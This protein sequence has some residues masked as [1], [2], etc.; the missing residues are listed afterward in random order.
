M[1]DT[2]QNP[3]IMNALKAYRWLW[4]SPVFTILTLIFVYFL[5]YSSFSAI[6]ISALW[7]LLLLRYVNDRTSD[8]VRWHGRQALM[9][10]GIR[11]LIPLLFVI[12]GGNYALERSFWPFILLLAAY[13]IGNI[14]GV[15]QAV[16]GDCWLMR[17][18]GTGAELPL[19]T[20][21]VEAESV[22]RT[23]ATSPITPAMA[24][25]SAE[26]LEQ[27]ATLNLIL[28][29][30]SSGDVTR[31]MKAIRELETIRFSSEAIVTQLERLALEENPTVRK[32]ALSALN[33]TTSQFVSSR[34]SS[35]VKSVRQI[36]L[37]EIEAWQSKGLIEARQAEVM[38]H[39]Y[40]F[41]IKAS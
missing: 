20:Q 33:L 11:T 25:N 39:R 41:D 7:H 12:V 3:Q 32:A 2:K 40:E 9:L 5:T 36:I 38:G 24:V 26:A 23:V 4:L 18:R 8:F 27:K 35:V 1:T 22:K 21:I 16:R 28:A 19:P 17:W 10:A 31:Q 30:L 15:N 6:F 37:A 34:L 29:K 13:F 14:W